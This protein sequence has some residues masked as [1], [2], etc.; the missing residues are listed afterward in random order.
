MLFINASRQ[1][2][3]DKEII[4][5][6]RLH[7]L[8]MTFFWEHLPIANAVKSILNIINHTVPGKADRSRLLQTMP[9]PNTLKNVLPFTCLEF[10]FFDLFRFVLKTIEF[11]YNLSHIL[12][13]DSLNLSEYLKIKQQY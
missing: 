2:Y 6:Y 11:R 7:N 9:K 8:M 5:K 13:F 1:L 4:M 3:C 12:F 10:P